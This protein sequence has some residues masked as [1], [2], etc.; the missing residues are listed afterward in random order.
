MFIFLWIVLFIIIGVYFVGNILGKKNALDYFMN[1]EKFDY[2]GKTYKVI[3]V[4][5]VEGKKWK[6]SSRKK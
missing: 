6:A 4:K 2:D 5:K 1:S 3:E